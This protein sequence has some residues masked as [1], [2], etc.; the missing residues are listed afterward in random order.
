MSNR[1]YFVQAGLDPSALS[2]ITAEQLLQMFSQ[3]VPLSNISF[4]VKQAGTSA[5]TVIPQGTLGSPSVG[6]TPEFARFIWLNS[7]TNPPTPY[8]YDS[9]EEKWKKGEVPDA[10]ITTDSIT[11]P[12]ETGGVPLSKLKADEQDE[13]VL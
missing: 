7:Y 3:M 12:S 13:T 9:A 6:D 1:Q 8:Y 4:N 2:T 11:E 5:A 10:S